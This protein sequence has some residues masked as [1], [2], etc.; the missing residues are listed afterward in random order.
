MVRIARHPDRWCN[1]GATSRTAAGQHTAQPAAEPTIHDGVHH[2]VTDG[3]EYDGCLLDRLWQR[4]GLGCVVGPTNLLKE[5][6]QRKQNPMLLMSNCIPGRF[7]VSLGAVPEII[8]R[9]GGGPQAL[10]CPVGEGCFVETCPRGGGGG[11][12]SRGSRHI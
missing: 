1:R 7:P 11:N 5:K 10:F 4:S 12:L 9:G 3:A 2:R 8:L 6:Q